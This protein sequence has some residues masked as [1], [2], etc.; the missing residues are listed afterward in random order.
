[1]ENFAKNDKISANRVASFALSLC[2]GFISG[3]ASAGYAESCAV[4]ACAAY[5]FDGAEVAA[6][7]SHA[8][9]CIYE[10]G[11]SVTCIKRIYSANNDLTLLEECSG[12]LRA[13]LGG[14]PLGEVERMLGSALS[15]GARGGAAFGGGLACGAFCAYFGGGAAEVAACFLIGMITSAISSAL[16]RR[17]AGGAARILLVS[18]FGGALSIIFC[19]LFIR[20]GVQCSV[21]LVVLGSIM[22]TIP[23]LQ[24]C[25]A[26]RDL[27][28]GDFLSGAYRIVG[29]LSST[30]A[31]VAG[32]ALSG[33]ALSFLGVPAIFGN[34]PPDMLTAYLSCGLGAAGFCIL[35]NA[36]PARVVS[37][38]ISAL[39]TYSIYALCSPAGVFFAV[40]V[41]S[42]AACF[43]SYALSNSHGAPS[44]VFLTPALVPL[45]PGAPLYYAAEG[46]ARGN[47]TRALAYGADALLFF[48]AIAAGLS[49]AAVA[50]R[51]LRALFSRRRRVFDRRKKIK[52]RAKK[53]YLFCILML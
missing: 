6:F 28:S 48:A 30:A 40:F 38:A 19:A 13:A 49:A 45:L 26:L 11:A 35:L 46:L 8:E 39:L 52:R 43:L 5:G 53:G 18:A 10:S 33:A 7:P 2:A 25:N 16:S 37:G 29:G 20:A 9:I 31:I 12:I 15:A 51:L 22:T 44:G 3:G 50:S 4:R 32:Y 14:A 34:S 23:G 36:R 27:L 41:S 21:A 17:G 42:S 24:L 1:M 47:L